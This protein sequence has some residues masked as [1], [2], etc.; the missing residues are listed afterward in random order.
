MSD[1]QTSDDRRF[2]D[3][4]TAGLEND[5]RTAETVIDAKLPKSAKLENEI[6]DWVDPDYGYDPNNPRKPNMRE[7]IKAMSG[8]NIEDLYREP[9][10]NWQKITEVGNALRRCQHD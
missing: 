7:L 1:D 6:P 4:L 2:S 8:K 5:D 3:L 9:E 10:E